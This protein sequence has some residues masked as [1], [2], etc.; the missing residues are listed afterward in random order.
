MSES[1][2]ASPRRYIVKEIIRARG[3]GRPP[4]RFY[5]V[6]IAQADPA[7]IDGERETRTEHT[8]PSVRA[9]DAWVASQ[10]GAVS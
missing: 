6:W 3:E 2:P 4:E 1:R 9:A 10:A 5:E 8:F 7:A